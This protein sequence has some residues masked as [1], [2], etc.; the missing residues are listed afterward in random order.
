MIWWKKKK[1]K[2][3][4]C[5]ERENVRDAIK[6]AWTNSEFTLM[7]DLQDYL[8]HLDKKIAKG[9]KQWQNHQ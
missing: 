3:T 2:L 5:E 8:V 9:K 1:S 4:L 7:Y 6:R